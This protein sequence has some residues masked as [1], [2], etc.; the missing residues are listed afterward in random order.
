MFTV[1]RALGLGAFLL[2]V[3]VGRA[4]QLKPTSYRS[5]LRRKTFL[6]YLL[7][8]LAFCLINFFEIE[9]LTQHLKMELMFSAA[10]VIGC[11]SCI[12]GGWLMDLKGRR[13]IIILALVMLGFGYALL[14]FFPFIL[15]AQVFYVIV[16]GI[17]FGILT[18]AF[19]FV[20]WGDIANGE[21]GEKFYA[22][23]LAP[24]PIAIGLSALVSPQLAKIDL[25]GA[26]SIASFFLFLAIIP[27][28]FAPELLPEKVI[29]ERELKK[30]VEEAKK[31][32]RRG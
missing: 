20:V 6:L 5:I 31:V 26:F 19:M 23:G 30:Y 3:D 2:H 17:A 25:S 27:I 18:V 32:A 29:K 1:W 4:V 24:V 9:V 7:P 15:P 28:F 8:W 13:W 14:S 12:A 16:D 21:Q 10:F 22:I 11:F